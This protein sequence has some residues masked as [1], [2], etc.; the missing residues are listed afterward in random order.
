MKSVVMNLDD[1][2]VSAGKYVLKVCEYCADVFFSAD[3]TKNYDQI[4]HAENFLTCCSWIWDSSQIIRLSSIRCNCFCV[5]LSQ[6]VDE[7]DIYLFNLFIYC[8]F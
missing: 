6:V 7:M 2:F 5:I 1:E 4:S 3:I 8:W